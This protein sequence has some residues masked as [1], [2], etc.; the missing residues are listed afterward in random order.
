MRVNLT[1]TYTEL[2]DTE[3]GALVAGT[4]LLEFIASYVYRIITEMPRAIAAYRVN[5]ISKVSG[6]R[7]AWPRPNVW[8]STGFEPQFLTHKTRDFKMF[9]CGCAST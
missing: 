1:P 4:I 8:L 7:I 5:A 2:L 9:L 3:E 6:I